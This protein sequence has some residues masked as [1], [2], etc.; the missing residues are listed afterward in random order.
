MGDASPDD[1]WRGRRGAHGSQPRAVAERES[2]RALRTRR[3]L[4]FGV[5]EGE[6]RGP[7]WRAPHH[8]VHSPGVRSPDDPLQRIYDAAELLPP[9][10]AVAGW[11]AAYLL[12]ATEL[13]GRGR[14]G[15]ERE[16][17]RL[18]LPPALH[19]AKRADIVH[20]RTALRPDDVHDVEG[21]PVTSP[22]RTAFDMARTARLDDAVVALD[23][24]AR[25]LGVGP[26]A[27]I[28]F[29]HEHRRFRGVPAGL[30]AARLADPLSRSTG[31]SRL[32]LLWVVDAGLPRPE[33]NP[34]VV[35]R[36]GM[37]LA[38]PDLL[39]TATGLAAEY[40]GSTHR[41]LDAH[42]QDN[43]REE[44][45]ESAGLVVV[46]VTSLDLGRDRARTVRRLL[47][48]YRRAASAD[49]ADR[50]WGWRPGRPSKLRDW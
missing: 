22:L 7:R 33:C 29:L 15:R 41:E 8:G 11:A 5:T 39:D 4:E 9:G 16:P 19:L 38:M 45:M 35:D 14:S 48:G 6:L 18:V 44:E 43:A 2:Q 25:R 20:W 42:T 3:L 50:S 37:V 40:D 26:D 17:V 21:I 24:L 31:E 47:D 1:V 34:L 27:V 49:R 30:R 13:D 36:D 12:G 28:A 32:R 23:V 46:R 10:G